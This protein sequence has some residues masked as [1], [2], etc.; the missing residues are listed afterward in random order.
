MCGITAI[1]RQD[2][3]IAEHEIRAMTD[4]LRHRGPD[5][6]GVWLNERVALGNR[7][8]AII[9]RAAGQQPMENEDETVI[10]SFNGEI[11]NFRELRDVLLGKGHAFKTASDTE[12]VVHA[13]EEWGENCVE[14]F[15]GMFA[16]CIVDTRKQCMF[17]A[18]DHFGIKPLF[19]FQWADC[20]AC[21]SELQALKVLEEFPWA[22]DHSAL[23]RYLWL[24][25]IPAPQ[26]VFKRVKKLPPAHR[27]IVHFDG[28]ID[29][30][31]LY[32]N[33]TFQPDTARTEDSFLEEL[34]DALLESVQAHM[35]A[36]VPVGAFLS[37]GVDS[38]TVTGYVTKALKR[39]LKT[40]SIGFEEEDYSELR[41]AR[42][43][44]IS[45]G[46]EHHTDVVRCD[47]LD[48]LPQLVRHYGEPFGDSSA[49]PTFA[50][51]RL[52][53][54]HVTVALSGDGGDEAFGGYASY[55]QW[56]RNPQN[57]TLED[58]LSLMQYLSHDWRTR[59]WRPEL[60][61]VVQRRCDIFEEAWT[62]AASGS[63]LQKVQYIDRRTYLPYAI[64][65][66]VDV[67]SMM[68][69]LEVR[70]PFLDTRVWDVAAR[71]PSNFNMREVAKGEWEGKLLLRRLLERW[72]PSNLVHRRKTGFGVPLAR[73]FA[74]GGVYRGQLEERLLD[75]SSPLSEYFDPSVIRELLTKN[76]T[77][78]LW[79]LL[80]L[81]EWLRQY[82][83]ATVGGRCHENLLSRRGRIA[84]PP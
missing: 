71:I 80:F 39:P 67:A 54:A 65:T 25:Y 75:P 32:W 4:T 11:Y 22:L 62:Q 43:A 51:S 82:Q 37:G 73:W 46:S 55:I 41:F 3:Y 35:V 61:H 33:R 68:H 57:R 72:Y 76:F 19:Y 30:P 23:D 6:E 53:R 13:Y 59:L 18:R 38:G 28:K 69:G 12:V 42:M 29:G 83:E 48:I 44:A 15:R 79:L 50:V 31:E 9:D 74:D 16:F 2:R 34:D 49:L 1:L 58:W 27:M 56:M 64:L 60:R 20:F 77:G 24:Q 84:C 17:L 81:D 21:A 66:K 45:A 63:P 5:G 10:V 7:R 8:L 52:A 14:K 78:P 26:T 47:V 70:P 40:F 36:D